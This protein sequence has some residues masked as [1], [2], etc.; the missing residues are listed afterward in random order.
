[1][2]VQAGT[3]NFDGEPADK[4]FLERVSQATAQHGPDGEALYAD[5]SLGMIYRPFHTT[6][7]AC[8]ERQPYVSPKGNVITW[9]GR[10]D[11]R[12][13]L[14][15][16]LDGFIGGDCGTDV[17]VVAAAFDKW[18]TDCF[19]KLLGD[20]ALTV[21]NPRERT[22]I[23][24]TDVMGI[25]HLYYHQT[26]K[27]IFWSTMLEPIVL[28]AADPWL[29]NGEF[30]AGYL[31]SYPPAQVTPYVGIDAVPPCSY[32]TIRRGVR[33][34]QQ[35]WHFD[36]R[37]KTHYR[38]DA[39]YEEH[40]RHVFKEA[41]RRR[42]RSQTPIVAELSGGM[43][44]TSIV[45]M[46]DVLVADGKAETPRLDTMSYYDDEEP[47][48]NERP[49]FQKVEEK[50]GRTGTHICIVPANPFVALSE[51]YFIAMPGADQSALHFDFER[52]ASFRAQANR[53]ILSG[54]GGDEVLGG[55]P[56]AV[57]ELSDL[58][59]QFR[60]A[61]F[62]SQLKAWSLV[63]KRPWTHMLI[64]S[65]MNMAGVGR[66]SGT[67]PSK[68]RRISWLD[69]NFLKL[70]GKSPT[71]NYALGADGCLFSQRAFLSALSHVRDQ[72]A[73]SPPS[74]VATQEVRYPYLDR[75]LCEFLF[76]VPRAQ[77]LRPTQRRSLMRR[78]LA[79]IVPPEIL[80]RKR[81]A[82]T[83]RSVMVTYEEAWPMLQD[84]FHESLSQKLQYVNENKFLQALLATIHGQ[85]ASLVQLNRTITLELWLR[86]LADHKC[87]SYPA[88]MR[89]EI[90]TPQVVHPVV[91]LF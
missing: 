87:L 66:Y 39:E 75:S 74:L 59:Q 48:W 32:V 38:T 56:T 16:Q 70:H 83:V 85:L 88:I 68:L 27:R 72:L 24:A 37:K 35:Y 77:I 12:E 3:W 10:L 90:T 20:W 86:M 73:L 71:N 21:W 91:N 82:F 55:V 15:S 49:Y 65:F 4:L 18:R 47:N 13:D 40:F 80:H 33:E 44:S 1:M 41:I 22:L 63:Q 89:K 5:G 61:E 81:K 62:A 14:T 58:L 64:K 79:G 7:E 67:L 31:A 51:N 78:A 11:N 46:A 25:R 6:K 53:V 28:L 45:C 2:S 57:P 9:D 29:I 23:L 54:I 69:H 17:A 42:L 26:P 50:R 30:V 8:F 76:S 43:D 60:L 84:R 52:E 36:P 34:I 19:A